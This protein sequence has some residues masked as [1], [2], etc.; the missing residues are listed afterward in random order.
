[1]MNKLKYVFFKYQPYWMATGFFLAIF[2][3]W[4]LGVLMGF[5]SLNSLLIG[6]LLFVVASAVYVLLLYRGIGQRQNL[7][8]LLMV[9]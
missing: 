4:W 8:R 3:V 9:G 7:E 1:M 6:I 5:S 2:L